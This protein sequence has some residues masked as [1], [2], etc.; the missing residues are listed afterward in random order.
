MPLLVSSTIGANVDGLGAFLALTAGKDSSASS[1]M[2][3]APLIRAVS[4][5]IRARRW[6]SG[7]PRRRKVAAG[8]RQSFTS[9]LGRLNNVVNGP[10]PSAGCMPRISH[11]VKAENRGKSGQEQSLIDLR[12]RKAVVP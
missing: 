4:P 3:A 9:F 6:R 12:Q 1:A 2:T 11:D 8:F 10:R 7:V 5:S